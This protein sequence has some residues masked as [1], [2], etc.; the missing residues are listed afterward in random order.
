MVSQWLGV[1]LAIFF[2]MCVFTAI[3]PSVERLFGALSA[4]LGTAV[5]QPDS[6]VDLPIVRGALL[7]FSLY[8]GTGVVFSLSG[9]TAGF[10]ATTAAATA[11]PLSPTAGMQCGFIVGVLLTGAA[12]LRAAMAS[13]VMADQLA[14]L[15]TITAGLAAF[16]LFYDSFVAI[17][18]T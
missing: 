12:R 5:R 14:A 16:V 8:F 11:I 7:L 6:Q 18:P 13:S 1:V 2:A 10:L 15:A 9:G 3:A 17:V 4:P